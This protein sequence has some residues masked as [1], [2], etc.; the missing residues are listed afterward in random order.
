MILT[1]GFAFALGVLLPVFMDSFEESREKAGKYHIRSIF[2][3]MRS[4]IKSSKF[5]LTVALRSEGRIVARVRFEP[6]L[7]SSHQPSSSQVN[8]FC[9]MFLVVLFLIA[10]NVMHQRYK[11]RK[12]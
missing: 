6:E 1:I 4:L 3:D 5:I 2:A 11:F 9:L 8:F 12:I 7:N 10:V